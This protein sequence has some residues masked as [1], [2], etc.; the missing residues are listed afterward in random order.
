[1]ICGLAFS[2]LRTC[3]V[4]FVA[5]GLMICDG[6]DLVAVLDCEALHVLLLPS[7]PGVLSWMT[8]TRV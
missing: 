4:S 1:M 3:G 7:P 5:P 6:D 2:R 8:A